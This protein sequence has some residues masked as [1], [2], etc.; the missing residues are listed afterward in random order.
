M[1]NINL[2]GVVIAGVIG[3]AVGF[4]WYG[5]IFGKLWVKLMGFTKEDMEEAQKKSMILSYALGLLGQFITAYALSILVA[6]SFQYFGGFSY[7]PILWIWLGIIVPIQM[8]AVLWER[9]P[10]AL[11]A[12]NCAYYLVQL[13][14]MGLVLSYLG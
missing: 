8:G 4:S 11:F 6:S 3:M 2:L 9:K 5:P 14:A 13:L 7:S 1:P 12:L 10:W